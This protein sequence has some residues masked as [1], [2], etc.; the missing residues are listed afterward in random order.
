MDAEQVEDEQTIEALIRTAATG[1]AAAGI[2]ATRRE[3]WLLLEHASGRG[4][5]GLIAAGSEPLAGP[6]AARFRTLVERRRQREPIAYILD[7]KEFWSLPFHL[8]RAV[9]TPRPESETVVE[10][11]LRHMAHRDA[12]RRILDLGTGSGCLLLA[13]LGELPGAFGV[14]VD[15]DPAAAGIA[16]ANARRFGLDHRAGF[17]RASWGQAL[18]GSFDLIVSNPPYVRAGDWPGLAPEIRRFEPIGALLAGADGLDAY[19]ALAPDAARLAA[20]AGTVCLEHGPGQGPAVR[21][22]MSAAGLRPI[23]WREDLAGHER[24]QILA[25][26]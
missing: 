7:E 8:G 26:P 24:V 25:K 14:G 15:L 9:L 18:A 12:P 4:R 22:I 10:A 21:A 17:V 5:A 19:R 23:E 20:A 11:A 1:L 2:D 3:A 13:L 6:A 16:R